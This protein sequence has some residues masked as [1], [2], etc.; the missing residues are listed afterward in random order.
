M[1]FHFF[2][3]E[4]LKIQYK[5]IIKLRKSSNLFMYE[6]ILAFKINICIW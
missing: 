1:C 4:G 6:L 5:K 2:L 3:C